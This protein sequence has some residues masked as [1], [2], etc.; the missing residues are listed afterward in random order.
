[1]NNFS[2]SSQLKILSQLGTDKSR[3]QG[4]GKAEIL[5]SGT[6]GTQT[7]VGLTLVVNR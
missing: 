4:L 5:D 1:M 3:D 2:N 7:I 6:E